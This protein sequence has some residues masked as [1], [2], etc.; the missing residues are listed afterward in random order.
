MYK[1]LGEDVCKMY[2]RVFGTR[3]EIARFYN[4]YGPHEITEGE[5]AAVIGKWRGNIAKGEPIVIHGD[6]EQRRDFT[7]VDDVVAANLLALTTSTGFG[8]VYNVGTGTNTSIKELADMI[9]SNQM[10]LPAR[11]GE[12]KETLADI[13]KIQQTLGW[14]PTITVKQYITEQLNR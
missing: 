14:K 4:V 2:R 9:S 13:A 10:S 5:W 1:K 6:G 3:I 11:V 7:H 8:E 12:S